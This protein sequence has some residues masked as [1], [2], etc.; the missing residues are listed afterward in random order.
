M[1]LDFCWRLCGLPGFVFLSVV[2]VCDLVLGFL[3]ALCGVCHFWFVCC[4]R[5]GGFGLC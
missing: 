2:T 3:V 5:P 1:V 4:L